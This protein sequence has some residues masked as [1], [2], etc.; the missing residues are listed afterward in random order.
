[1]LKSID[2][3][4][5]GQAVEWISRASRLSLKYDDFL[6]SY[7]EKHERTPGIHASELGGCGRKIVY[8][9]LGVEQNK[10]TPPI[11]RKRFKV[12]HAI[13]NMFQQDFS[14]MAADSNGAF[15]FEAEVPI[16]PDTSALANKWCIYSSCDG[17]FTYWEREN[18]SSPWQQV[19]RVGLEI[20]TSSDAEFEKLRAP[21]PEHVDQAHI[22]MA[23]LDLP[24]MWFLYFNKGNQNTT[25]STGPWMTSFNSKT[26]SRLESKMEGLHAA[27][28]SALLPDREESIVCEFCAFRG[29][30]QPKWLVNKAGRSG[31]RHLSVRRV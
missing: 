5:K 20:K 17:V 26:W 29:T 7:K 18:E 31:H 21:K 22:Y 25:P 27:A 28:D 1:V 9:L 13:H 24:V 6:E 11:W 15:T 14:E 2:D 10:N 3:L 19:L 23:C 12:G 30:C 8:N 16:N 4:E